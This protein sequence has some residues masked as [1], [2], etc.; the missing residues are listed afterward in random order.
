MCKA[1]QPPGITDAITYAGIVYYEEK[2]VE[3]VMKFTAAKKLNALLE[4][5]Y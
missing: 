3:D 2:G 4:V 5:S 1:E